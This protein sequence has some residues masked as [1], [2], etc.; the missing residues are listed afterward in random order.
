MTSGM[1]KDR[2]AGRTSRP[3]VSHFHDVDVHCHEDEDG[4]E[5]WCGGEGALAN[6]SVGVEFESTQDL[7]E[8]MGEVRDEVAPLRQRW[9]RLQVRWF[10]SRQ[11]ATELPA[12]ALAAGIALP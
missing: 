5:A 8:F 3:D 6:N 12:A 9:P 1:G 11:P 10:E 7:A 2:L 4:G